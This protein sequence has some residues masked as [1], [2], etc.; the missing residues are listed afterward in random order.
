MLLNG[1]YEFLNS[2]LSRSNR[3]QETT[4]TKSHRQL[5]TRHAS[6]SEYNA[7]I[8]TSHFIVFLLNKHDASRRHMASLNQTET[9]Q[10]FYKG[11]IAAETPSE[12]NE[13]M[14]F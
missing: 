12:C 3:Y 10:D 13:L 11:K 14:L 8:M 2:K 5:Q 7:L 1:L 9:C 4:S 6:C